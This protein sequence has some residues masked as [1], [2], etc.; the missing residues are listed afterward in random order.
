[1]WREEPLSDGAW[2][3]SVHRRMEDT[4]CMAQYLFFIMNTYIYINQPITSFAFRLDFYFNTL[5]HDNT[6]S[7]RN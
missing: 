6:T 2:N 1:M 5:P 3:G 4:K 7:C